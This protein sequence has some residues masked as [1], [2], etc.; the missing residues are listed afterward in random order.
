MPSHVRFED[1]GLVDYASTWDY[2]TS[3]HRQLVE[4]KRRINQG[5]SEEGPI[6]HVF[7]LCEHPHVYTLGKSGHPDHVLLNES[8][9]AAVGATYFKINRG[10][11]ITYHG[12]GQIVG[13]PILDLEDFY[14]DVHRYVRNLEEVMIRVIAHYGLSGVRLDGYTGV[15]LEPSGNQPVFRKICAIGVHLSRWVTL[16]GFAFN[17][18]TELH[19]FDHII[20]CGINDQEKAVT[21]LSRELGYFLDME[22]VKSRLRLEFETI[23][24]CTLI[25]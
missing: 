5:F 2:Q 7:I 8:E 17:V 12:P 14:R 25:C 22:E 24:A 6:P 3:C 4:R 20:P 10:G 11:D 1:L 16:H 13:Y 19:Y 23:F 9:L 21:S 18:N 15:W